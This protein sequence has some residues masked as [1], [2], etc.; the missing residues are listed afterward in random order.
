MAALLLCGVSLAAPTAGGEK[1]LNAGAGG[2]DNAGL[3]EELRV[4]AAELAAVPAESRAL[5]AKV[6]GRLEGMRGELEE[7]KAGK[8][9]LEARVAELD[10][11]ED[12]EAMV[13]EEKEKEAGA[14]TSLNRRVTAL[15][16]EQAERRRTQGAEP[17]PEPEP[18]YVHLIKREAT[19]GCDESRCTPGATTVDG[20]FDYSICQNP[21]LACCYREACGGHRRRR[22]QANGYGNGGRTPCDASDL[23][24]R[25]DAVNH[26]CCD[27]DGE[28][29]TGGYPRSCNAGCAAVFLAFWEDCQSALGKDTRSFEPVV[30]LCEAVAPAVS[31][32]AGGS[33][34]EQMSV[35]CTDGTA[36]EACIPECGAETHGWILLLN[37]DGTDTKFSCS[38]AHGL[39][40]WMGAASEG[41]A[42]SRRWCRGWRAATS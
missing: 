18:E 41:G 7:L 9:E 20:T 21:A 2:D 30:D 31:T 12:C 6:L 17:E 35:Q 3:E 29:C 15:E 36:A 32:G 25:S 11:K 10:E 24:G 42:S 33:L 19:T 38:L 13:K 26:E 4:G 27:E 5:F 22:A 14:T 1:P 40:S 23:P 28:D 16:L 34:A 39:Y 8:L 37:L